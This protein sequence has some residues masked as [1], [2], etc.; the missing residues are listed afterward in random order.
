MKSNDSP[1][2]VNGELVRKMK[3]LVFLFFCNVCDDEFEYKVEQGKGKLEMSWKVLY[4]RNFEQV[5]RGKDFVYTQ[6]LGFECRIDG[7]PLE[8]PNCGTYWNIFRGIKDG[9]KD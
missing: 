7:L 5:G 2:W 8:C 3:P 6:T 4:K 9:D 1:Q